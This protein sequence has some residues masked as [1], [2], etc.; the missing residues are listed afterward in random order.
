MERS[1]LNGMKVYLSP[2][3]TLPSGSYQTIVL[4]FSVTKEQYKLTFAPTA[5]TTGSVSS[6]EAD[7]QK[8]YTTM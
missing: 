1:I 7:I 6:P 5:A 2:Q 4:A 8:I 3:T